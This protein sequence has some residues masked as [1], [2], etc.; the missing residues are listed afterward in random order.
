V[1]TSSATTDVIFVVSESLQLTSSSFFS[2]FPKKYANPPPATFAA[3]KPSVAPLTIPLTPNLL[4]N[5]CFLRRAITR[6]AKLQADVIPAES[7][8]NPLT[9]RYDAK[10]ST[11]G[12]SMGSF[13]RGRRCCAVMRVARRVGGRDDSPHDRIECRAV[14]FT[15]SVGSPGIGMLATM[16]AI[17]KDKLD[18]CLQC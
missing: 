8:G 12:N 11:G 7:T 6:Y 4:A 16:A 15:S 2:L 1:R 9:L 3:H 10:S 17:D 13:W 18:Y 5:A 14:C